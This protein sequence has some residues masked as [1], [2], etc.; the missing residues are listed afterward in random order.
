MKHQKIAAQIIALK[1]ADLKLRDHL[2]QSGQLNDGYNKEMEALHNSN[3]TELQEII[4]NIGYPTINKVGT[5][6]NEAAWLVI[7]HA[8][9]QPK[10]MKKCAE[11]LAEAVEDNEANPKQLAYLSDRIAMFENEPQQYGT[12][13][14]WD[15]HGNLSPL[16]YDNLDQVNQRRSTIGLNTLEEQTALIR[17]R[18]ELENEIPP[19]DF[20]KRKIEM[21]QWRR[22]VGWIS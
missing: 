2:I 20:Q 5:E 12:Q 3:A 10:F 19:A 1:N 7:Q 18:A 22:S 11:L 21:D 14:D 9:G 6:A 16:P 17:E 13:F 4:D 15:Q 8:I